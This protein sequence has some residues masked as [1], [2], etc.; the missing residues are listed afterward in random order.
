[1]I[2]DKRRRL[3]LALLAGLLLAQTVWA[4]GCAGVQE[5]EQDGRLQVVTTVFAV[6]DFARVVGGDEV[7]VTLLLKPG[8][9]SHTYEPTPQDMIAVQ[10][11]DVFLYIGGESES[12]VESLLGSSQ[13]SEGAQTVAL[14]ECVEALSEEALP[15]MEEEEDHEEEQEEYDEHIWTSPKNAMRM[16]ERIA[17]AYAAADPENAEAYKARAAAYVEELEALD[18]AFA[19][20]VANAERTELVFGDRFPLLYFVKEYG[21]DYYAAFPGCSADT[22][23]DAQTVAFL[24][25]RVKEDGIP[26]VFHTELANEGLTDVI[27][28]ETGAQK[29]QFTAC[30][31]VTQADF[32]AGKTYLDF[33]YENVAVL[34]EALN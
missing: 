19:E 3:R 21:L 27:C 7:S 1:M 5:A 26:V 34:E 16:T 6:Y 8:A 2:L 17:E 18:A 28:E 13:M 24:I 31:N 14:M 29:R 10:S 9:E 33:M 20:V 11:C 30:H 32:E 4:A 23:A 22:E 15:G 25:D 12:W